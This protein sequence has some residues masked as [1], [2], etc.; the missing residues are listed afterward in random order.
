MHPTS[1]TAEIN[2]SVSLLSFSFNSHLEAAQ[3]LREGALAKGAEATLREVR[4][5][6][7]LR[8]GLLET[9]SGGSEAAR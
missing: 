5:D 4:D 6:D 2:K 9:V 3:A 7:H 1:A 8:R